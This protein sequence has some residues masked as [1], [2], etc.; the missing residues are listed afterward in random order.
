M[1]AKDEQSAHLNP[2]SSRIQ[3]VSCLS[4]LDMNQSLSLTKCCESVPSIS[5]PTFPKPLWLSLSLSRN[6]WGCFL[7]GDPMAALAPNFQMLLTQ[8]AVSTN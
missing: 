7:A 6:A 3:G 2:C 8:K 4:F 1:V 5:I